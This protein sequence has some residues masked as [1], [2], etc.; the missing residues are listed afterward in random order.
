MPWPHATV[1]GAGWSLD[2]RLPAV[3]AG[4]PASGARGQVGRDLPNR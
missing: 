3:G 2:R 4:D 1:F